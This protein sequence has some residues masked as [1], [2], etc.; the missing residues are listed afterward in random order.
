MYTERYMSTPQDN[1]EGYN[2][3]SVLRYTDNF[4]GKPY[5]LVHGNA[6]DNVSY[7]TQFHSNG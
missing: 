6:D 3:S 5:L 4:K 1:P 7:S 2:R